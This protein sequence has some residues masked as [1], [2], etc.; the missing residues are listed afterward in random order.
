MDLTIGSTV[1][2]NGL[3]V[4]RVFDPRARELHVTMHYGVGA[5]DDPVGQEGVA[6]L[7]E[8]LMFQ[9]VVGAQSIFAKLEGAA[10]EYNAF[11][12]YDATEYVTD[13]A[14]GQLDALLFIE[15]VRMNLRCASITESVFVREREVVLQ[16]QRIRDQSTE[17][18]TA[19]HRGTYP[20]AHPY[21]RLLGGTAETVGALTLKQA[22][23]FADAHYGPS[24]AVLVVSGNIDAPTLE[25]AVARHLAKIPRRALAP[26]VELPVATAVRAVETNAPIDEDAVL[27]AWPLPVEPALRARVSA[28]ASVAVDY[29]DSS[30]AG[31][32]TPRL[33]GDSRAPMF[34][35]VIEPGEDESTG[36]IIKTLESALDR[37]PQYFRVRGEWGRIAFNLR[38]QAAIHV[39]FAAFEQGSS[40][41]RL[42]AAHVHAGLA[43]D[44]ALGSALESLRTLTAEDAQA[45]MKEYLP[46]AKAN[47]VVLRASEQT[48]GTT[49]LSTKAPVHDLGQRRDTD[50]AHAMQPATEPVATRAIDGMIT[51]TLANGMRVILL[52]VTS[53]PIVDARVVFDAGTADENPARRGAAIVAARGLWISMKYIN[54]TLALGEA[55]ATLGANAG[56]D[57]TTFQTTG[58]DMH[59]DYMLAGLRR[60]VREGTYEG[61]SSIVKAMRETKKSYDDEGARTDA[62]RTAI[63]G[64][65]HPYR[66]AGM[67]RHIAQDLNIRDVQAFRRAYYTPDN[68][69]IIIAGKFDP[70]VAN[71]WVDYL[72]ADWTTNKRRA[73]EQ[74][75]TTVL[76]ASIAI[77]DDVAQTTIR[78]AIPSTVGTRA[79]RLITNEM[80]AGIARDVRHQLGASYE[81]GADFNEL[82]RSALYEI[83]G[84]IDAPRTSEAIELIRS[85]VEKL[86]AD[87]DAAARAFVE[88]RRRVLSALGDVMNTASTLADRVTDDI[89]LGRAPLSDIE[90][91][92][93]VHDLTLR[94]VSATLAELDLARAA[95]AMRGPAAEI[96]KAFA[97]LG[98]TPRR[99]I[100]DVEDPF[101]ADDTPIVFP[102]EEPVYVSDVEDALTFQRPPRTVTFGATAGYAT[103]KIR[104]HGGTTGPRASV[105]GGLRLDET[106]A[107]GLRASITQLDGT[108]N[109]GTELVPVDAPIEGTIIS[110]GAYMHVTAYDRLYGGLIVS[111]NT[112]QTREGT[113]M[114][115]R[116]SDW[117]PGVAI[118]LEGGID[119]LRIGR[120][121]IGLLGHLEGEVAT[122]ASWAGF[123][124]GIGYRSY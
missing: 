48:R 64:P 103:G 109:V 12:S 1:L 94:D 118:G 20:E 9:Q 83:S 100:G 62:W 90:V 102:D 16:E 45:L 107:I 124:F 85:R 44:K 27:L 2:E 38:Q 78:I 121:R 41:D 23:A 71:R 11:T 93:E 52:P 40:R 117:T 66:V 21:A 87:P 5:A 18:R 53:V 67:P 84:S 69:T 101:A 110:A 42:L 54:D 112:D 30:I 86:R 39:Q 47:I 61:A 72:Y 26:R 36:D 46:Y 56:P 113:G 105:Y 15:F 92:R 65:D 7:V 106:K 108:Y 123:S 76:P 58:L 77:D 60:L 14:A 104:Q 73:R 22:C 31:R 80:L 119:L 25:A 88:A 82:R 55:G 43:P 70:A 120:H 95:V 8:H 19:M 99:I 4:V 29:I 13:A 122:D 63:Y 33:L 37:A 68:A 74:T 75:P 35:V 59:L 98:R 114:L 24:N 57:R 51:R 96:D 81:L 49:R 34:G 79:Q 28:V 3:R 50:P 10:R 17:M 32:V 97:A 6:H 91:A 116:I 111:V 89:G 115:A